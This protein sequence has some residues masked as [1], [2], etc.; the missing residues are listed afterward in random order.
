MNFPSHS[1][2]TRSTNETWPEIRVITQQ[3]TERK[4]QVI[5][6]ATHPNLSFSN[7]KEKKREHT[8]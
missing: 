3:K 2:E 5:H 1:T 6:Q 7:Q 8:F 4:P